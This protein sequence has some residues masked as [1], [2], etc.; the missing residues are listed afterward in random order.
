MNK[1][2]RYFFS[3]L[4]VMAI[5]GWMYM[6]GAFCAASFDIHAWDGIGRFFVAML[7]TVGSLV[8][9]STINRWE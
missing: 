7:A 8:A 1:E 4:A 2:E 6:F 3:I 9:V 5:C